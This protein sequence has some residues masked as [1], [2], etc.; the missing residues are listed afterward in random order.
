M[1]GVDKGSIEV[2]GRT[3][4]ERVLAALH[5]VADVVV[6][7]DEVRTSRPVTFSKAAAIGMWRRGSH[8]R[9]RRLA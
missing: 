4:L 6:V 3:L 8:A 9:R 5:H 2:G 7:G 1:G